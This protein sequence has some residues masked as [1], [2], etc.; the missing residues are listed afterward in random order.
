MENLVPSDAY[1]VDETGYRRRMPLISGIALGCFVL[2]LFLLPFLFSPVSLHLRIIFVSML[3]FVGGF[4]TGILGAFGYLSSRPKVAP[5]IEAI[6]TNASGLAVLPP[7]GKEFSYRVPC[8][9]LK[10]PNFKVSGV[11]YI[12]KEGLM[13]M[14]HSHQHKYRGLFEFDQPQLQKSLEIAP[15]ERVSINVVEAQLGILHRILHQRMPRFVEMV[16]PGGKALFAVPQ[17]EQTKEKIERAISSMGGKLLG[18]SR[19]EA[20]SAD[21][22]GTGWVKQKDEVPI[23]S[24]DEEGLTP[25][26]RL[27]KE[28]E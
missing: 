22:F 5:S 10:F 28:D 14:P 27:L 11:L 12:G 20:Q 1:D 25:L 7:P 23:K 17:A 21:M 16:W 4:M 15:L 9:W 13:F 18:A 6:Y 8:L 24:F 19:V 2:L 26:G 3:A